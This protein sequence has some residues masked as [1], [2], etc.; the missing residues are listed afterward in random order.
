MFFMRYK[1]KNSGYTLVELIT[2]ISIMVVIV[3]VASFSVSLMF[4]R[5]A[6]RAAVLI[7]DSLSETRMLAMSKDG[8]VKMIIRTDTDPM[9]NTIEVHQGSSVKKIG[10]DRS[11]LISLKGS[12]TTV[13]G[14]SITIEF[15]KS[16]GSV[17]KINGADAVA[18]GL[19]EIET[20]AQRGASKTSKVTLV[21]NTGRHYTD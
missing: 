20:V 16:N 12:A 21:A 19:Y 6:Q 1:D 7:D 14:D 9:K 10:I 18:D 5:D 13:P 15:N 8:D 4:S 2:V 3:G 17:S 11:V